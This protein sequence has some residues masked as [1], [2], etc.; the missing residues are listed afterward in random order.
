TLS[1]ALRPVRGLYTSSDRDYDSMG[2]RGFSTPGTYN[3]RMLVLSDGH[4]T[5]EATIGQGYV[6][7]EFD[8]DLADVERIEIVR[9]PGSVLYGS[10]A[11]FAV[12]NV[13]H[14]TPPQ[15]QH[16][17]VEAMALD[18]QGAHFNVSSSGEGTWAALHAGVFRASGESIFYSP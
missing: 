17:A 11:F 1:E 18:Q 6:G 10:A 7:R 8:A 2:V 5:N 12:V 15:G 4:V 3:N 16:G 14:K 13:V 9:G